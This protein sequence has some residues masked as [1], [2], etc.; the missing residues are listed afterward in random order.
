LLNSESA[1]A[2]LSNSLAGTISSTMENTGFFRSELLKSFATHAA[3]RL[4]SSKLLQR[5]SATFRGMNASHQS[6]IN[7]YVCSTVN[8]VWATNHCLTNFRARVRLMLASMSSAAKDGADR[9]KSSLS[10]SASSST[11]QASSTTSPNGKALQAQA[12]SEL[13]CTEEMEA[14]EYQQVTARLVGCRFFF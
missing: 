1:N 12:R 11:P 14:L 10:Q 9:S 8:C 4:A 7:L 3:V 2:L 5:Y 6:M 13:T